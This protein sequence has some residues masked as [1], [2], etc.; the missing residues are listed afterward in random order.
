[1]DSSSLN[2]RQRQRIADAVTQRMSYLEQM[3]E[4]TYRLGFPKEDPLQAATIKAIEAMN[5]LR[6]VARTVDTRPGWIRARN[7]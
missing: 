1:M 5:E 3:L 7:G 6:T 2:Q 4:R